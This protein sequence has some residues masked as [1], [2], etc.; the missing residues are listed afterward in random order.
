MLE[1]FRDVVC[2]Q[3]KV[4]KKARDT[5]GSESFIPPPIP[6]P[7]DESFAMVSFEFGSSWCLR[8]SSLRI[9]MNAAYTRDRET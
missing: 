9:I 5:D 2:M 8:C 3:A 7:G 1:E 6:M 4:K